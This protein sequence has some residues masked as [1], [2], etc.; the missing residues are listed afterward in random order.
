M[1]FCEHDNFSIKYSEQCDPC[2]T[3]YIITS[4]GTILECC[5]VSVL[6][7]ADILSQIHVLFN[8]A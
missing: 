6:K 2:T 8:S 1:L 5:F 3:P 7:V 4:S